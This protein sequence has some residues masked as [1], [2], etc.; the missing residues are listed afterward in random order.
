MCSLGGA[1][2]PFSSPITSDE[3]YLSPP[4]EFPE[5]EEAWHRSSAMKLSPSQTQSTPDTSSRA[6]PIFK[7]SLMDQSV[8]EGQDV[9]MSI[10]VQGEPK[11][12]VSWLRNH[13]PVRPDQRRFAEEAEG[14]LCRLRIL[15]AERGDAGFYTCKAVNEYGTRQCE[16]RLEVRGE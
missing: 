4:E 10:R 6:P 16:A 12:V 13:Q 9:T 11:P 8:R 3:E 7:V 14:G 2:S 5:P 1:T 15:A